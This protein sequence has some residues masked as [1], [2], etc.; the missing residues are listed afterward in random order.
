MMATGCPANAAATE[1]PTE[2]VD[3]PVPPFC[4]SSEIL[5]MFTPE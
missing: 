1:S 2:I 4:P 3:F 5:N